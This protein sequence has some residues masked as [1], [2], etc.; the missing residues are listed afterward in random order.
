M[1]FSLLR[2]IRAR[3]ALAAMLP[4]TLVTL[5]LSGV[6]LSGRYDD[7]DDAHQQW[8]RTLARQV[9]SASEY[10]L[11]AANLEN[12]Q[13]LTAGAMRE[14]GVR[15][16]LVLD[17]Q[18]QVLAASGS[19]RLEP[20]SLTPR[21]I[22]GLE[23][24]Y[25]PADFLPLDGRAWRWIDPSSGDEFLVQPVH[26]SRLRLDEVY[27]GEVN[28]PE[29]GATG[30]LG[31]VMVEISREVLAQRSRF[32]L[33]IGLAVMGGGLLLGLLM[34]WLLGRGVV[35]PILRVSRMIGRIGAGDLSVRGELLPDD[36]LRALQQGL[37]QM[38]ERLQR[39]HEELEQRVAQATT[40]LRARKEEA[41]LA[42]QAKSRFLAAASHDLRQPI[43]ALGMFV[44]RLTQ[45]PHDAETR[46]LIG[47]LEASVRAMQDLLDA[48]LDVSRLD[49][50]A[51]QAQVRPVPLAPLLAQLRGALL[52]VAQDKGLHFRVRQPRG[53]ELW[54]RTDPALLHRILL[55]LLSNALR[56]TSEGGVLLSCRVR[57]V[58]SDGSAGAGDKVLIE[59][60]DTGVGIAPEHQE[61]IFRE[62]YQIGN[63]ERD[64]SKGLGLGLNIVHR[65]ARLLGHPL[66]LTSRLRRG[67]RFTLELPLAPEGERQFVPPAVEPA[68]GPDDLRGLRVLV[69]EDDGASAHALDGLLH[70]WGCTVAV[71]ESLRDA[72]AVIEDGF[73]PDVLLSDYRL[74]AG[75]NGMWA[76]QGVRQQMRRLAG[77]AQ[78]LRPDLPAALMSGD[79]DPDLIQLCREIS[80]PLLH[81]PVRPAKLRTL[82][83]RLSQNQA[84][85]M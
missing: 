52:P 29:L 44:A 28:G 46:R 35:L 18:G 49:A 22:M 12:L 50:D 15:M 85:S 84:L 61:D 16:V 25:L 67:T 33:G 11:F 72:L 30:V 10:G 37:N 73:E 4:V 43:H 48:L 42:T 75:E 81:K 68:R 45:L 56:Y 66:R 1:P 13:A 32:M 27:E 51:V 78:V 36:P 59:V 9:A 34:A 14:S 3:M 65:T 71:V 58:M 31:Y 70:S 5:V 74:R 62:F 60:W 54:V 21:V 2:D 6:F 20:S 63:P 53:A 83:R 64:R 38:A 26:S 80:L 47:N 8:T 79:T 76:V 39:H 57:R 69:I 23:D 24:L 77:P 40:E 19:V 55:N 82:L 41:E 7:L 17:A